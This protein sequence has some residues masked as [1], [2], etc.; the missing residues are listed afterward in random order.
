[1][2]GQRKMEAVLNAIHFAQVQYKE[3]IAGHM[4]GILVCID[5]RTREP[6]EKL[7]SEIQGWRRFTIHTEW[8]WDEAGRSCNLSVSWR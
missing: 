5:Q 4:E 2:A 7:L 8:A 6:H 1:M 3:T